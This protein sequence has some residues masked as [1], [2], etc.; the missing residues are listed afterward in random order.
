VRGNLDK[1]RLHGLDGLRG[2]ACV[3]IVALHVWMFTG[4]K[5]ARVGPLLAGVVGELRV[6]LIAFFV[7]SAYLL[8]GPWLR[9]AREGAGGPRL[10]RFAVHRA[11]RILPGYWLAIGG[12]FALLAATGSP[13]GAAAADLPVFAL[14][15]QNH[16]D[17]TRGLL[18]PPAWSLAVEVAFYA[19]LPLLGWLL[20]RLARRTGP[21]RAA[22]A[23]AGA[24]AA[25]G[26]GWTL[27]SVLGEWPPTVTS[28]LPTYLPI[29][30]C[31]LAAAA[32]PRPATPGRRRALLAA[33]A[34]LVALNGVWH[35]D[36][37]GL[38]GHVLRDLPAAAGFGLMV[39]ALAAGPA[40]L[41]ELAPVRWLG[42]VS[43]GAYLWHMPVLFV[44]RAE[45]RMPVS[46]LPAF[47]LVLGLTLVAAAVSWYGVE[48][49]AVR[50]A[51]A[52]RRTART[53][54]AARSPARTAPSMYP[55]Q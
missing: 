48:R 15:G 49:P 41:L 5:D 53:S 54:R 39:P 26:L 2:L 12:A 52:R 33:G 3:A 23:V 36:G 40:G 13:R 20:V 28:S 16:L 10:G 45:G 24:M 25:A 43:Y 42:T 11:A 32:L 22:L 47:A 50:W 4:A 29:F 30:A 17:R 37:T 35:A 46:P 6:G 21:L 18:V 14:F 1:R 31:G 38:A 55:A 51:Q 34:L 8:A 27:A 7:L 19:L 9:A 44:L